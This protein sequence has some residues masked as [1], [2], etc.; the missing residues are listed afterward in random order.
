MASLQPDQ[1]EAL[2]AHYFEHLDTAE[3]AER[4][5][6]SPGAVRELMRRAR[7]NLKNQLGSAS[8]WLSSH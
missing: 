1:R 3:V 2:A 7:E 5:G 4:M 6:R 8:A